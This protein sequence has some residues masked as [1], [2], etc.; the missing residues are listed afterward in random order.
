MFE[1]P[2]IQTIFTFLNMVTFLIF[3]A[4]ISIELNWQGK[5]KVT[6]RMESCPP[7]KGYKM[8]HKAGKVM[9]D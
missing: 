8:G 5:K 3:Y 4:N 2:K 1:N 9:G 7:K 6:W